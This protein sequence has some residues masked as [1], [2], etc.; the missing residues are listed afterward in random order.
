[1]LLQVGGTLRKW[2]LMSENRVTGSVPSNLATM[3]PCPSP[4]F[5]LCHAVS[6]FALSHALIKCHLATSSKAV[7]CDSLLCGLTSRPLSSSR[8]SHTHIV[9][10]SNTLIPLLGQIQLDPLPGQRGAGKSPK[11]LGRWEKTKQLQHDTALSCDT[12][13]HCLGDF[14]FQKL[15]ILIL[16]I[17]FLHR[18]QAKG[19]KPKGGLWA[20]ME[21]EAPEEITL[22]SEAMG[23]LGREPAEGY[24]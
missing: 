6:A 15:I 21:S 20:A 3:G 13:K 19:H 16:R 8:F 9:P 11:G 23:S 18:P 22:G 10:E 2:S 5:T 7:T 17:L 24:F 12:Q 1:M 4:S 14:F